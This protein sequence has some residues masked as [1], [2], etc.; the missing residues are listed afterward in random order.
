MSVEE[1]HKSSD[2]DE[3]LVLVDDKASPRT[4]R[5]FCCACVRRI[6]SE[7]DG[8]SACRRAVEVAE[9]YA[10]G[11]ATS[12]QL[13]NAAAEADA[14]IPH[15]DSIAQ[16]N[17]R[18]A[19]MWCASPTIDALGICRS[20]AWGAAYSRPHQQDEERSAQEALLR[21]LM[22]QCI[23]PCRITWDSLIRHR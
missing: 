4:M 8:A 6:W 7:L 9:D 11:N 22:Q 17:A 18:R 14:L 10:D 23:E 5:L 2:P 12:Q 19:A 3:L 20:V 15:A 16:K 21:E 1:W 13:A